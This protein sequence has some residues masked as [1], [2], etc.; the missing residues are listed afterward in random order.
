[1]TDILSIFMCHHFGIHA[2]GYYIT[3]KSAVFFSVSQQV[4]TLLKQVPDVIWH[5]Q[6]LIRYINELSHYLLRLCLVPSQFIHWCWFSWTFRNKYQWNLN[7]N[8]KVF[9]QDVPKY[10]M[11]ILDHIVH[12]PSSPQLSCHSRGGSGTLE[13]DRGAAEGLHGVEA[14]EGFVVG[15][16]SEA[17][18]ALVSL[19]N[20]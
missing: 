19:I 11:Q 3:K 12:Q 13:R 18:N 2:R 16:Y 4:I 8:I 20:R 10:H 5:H 14:L 9:L 17:F 1:M 15:L 7:Q 6:A